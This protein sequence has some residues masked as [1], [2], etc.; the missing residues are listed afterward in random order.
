MTPANYTKN[1]YNKFYAEFERDTGL[2]RLSPHELRHTCGTLLYKKTGD[3]YAVSKF[4][5]HSSI[6]ITSQYYVH[7]DV[8]MLRYRLNI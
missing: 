7:S 1:R 4:L 3:I 5:G 2:R 6:A 8:D